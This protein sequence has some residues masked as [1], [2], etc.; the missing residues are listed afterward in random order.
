MSPKP[1]DS[2]CVRPAELRDLDFLV[3]ANLGVARETE[4]KALDEDV[5]RRGA[6]AV[7]ER[8]GLGRYFVA[9]RAGTTIA[10][11]L[12]TEEW[13]DWH[14]SRYLWIQSVWV[15]PEERGRGVYRALWEHVKTEARE[16]PDVCSLRLCVEFENER[17]QGVYEHL[18]MQALPYRVYTYD[19][20]SAPTPAQLSELLHEHTEFDDALAE[21]QRALVR[22]DLEVARDAF[23]RFSLA[24]SH[25]ARM[26]D[27]V[28]FPVYAPIG[29]G[30]VG[31]GLELLAA[32]HSKLGRVI[33]SMSSELDELVAPLSPETLVRWIE[34]EQMLKHLLQHHD[35]RER[36]L[37][38]PALDAALDEGARRA[39]WEAVEVWRAENPRQS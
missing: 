6:Q 25:H 30:V 2:L 19:T 14:A 12:L 20:S 5:V 23:R 39:L 13:S 29:A 1:D 8:V 36:N 31:G 4:A 38:Y 27:E 28:V 10:S 26:E 17:A 3:R 33:E 16:A 32:E 37:V 22:G 15:E 11:L 24:L 18:G 9:D 35:Q 7:L 21:H 34:R